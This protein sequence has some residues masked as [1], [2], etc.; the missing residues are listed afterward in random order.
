MWYPGLSH[1]PPPRERERERWR[2]RERDGE[3][4]SESERER[5]NVCARE[6]ESGRELLSGGQI[7][8]LNEPQVAPR[9][10]SRFKIK[11]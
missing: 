7:D 9:R 1:T 11:G 8:L 6:R 4:E 2:E 3:R 5:E 10:V